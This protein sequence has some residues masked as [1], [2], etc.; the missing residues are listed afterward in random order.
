MNEIEF[1]KKSSFLFRGICNFF[2][3][4]TLWRRQYD[5]RQTLVVAGSTRSGSTWLAEIISAHPNAGQIF[6]PISPTNVRAARRCG[7]TYDTFLEPH[8]NSPTEKAYLDKVLRGQVLTPWTTSQIP[9]NKA[10][11]CRFLVVK[12]VRA[13]LL[14]GWLANSFPIKPPVL[15][16]RHPCATIASQIKKEWIPRQKM[17]LSNPFFDKLPALREACSRFTRPEELLAL[18]WSMR[19]YAPLAQP[20]P[21][22]FYLMTYEGLVRKGQEEVNRLFTNWGLTVPPASISR[23]IHPSKTVTSDSQV[24]MKRN[25]LSG[26]RKHLSKEQISNILAIVSL[27]GLNFYTESLEP[28]EERLQRLISGQEQLVKHS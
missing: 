23:L 25:P 15:I 26:W 28:D 17:L 22:P 18:R 27:F 24:V 6:E 13:N 12:F 14:L 16:V 10:K 4:N 19:Y 20:A 1:R 8:A 11:H 7:F 3:L 5:I 2:L 21:F 9:I